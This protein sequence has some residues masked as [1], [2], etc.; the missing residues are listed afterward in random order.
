[1]AVVRFPAGFRESAPGSSGPFAAEHGVA[2]IDVGSALSRPVD[3]IALG[4]AF[5]REAPVLL[6]AARAITSD[7]AEAEDLVQTTFELAIRRVHQLRDPNALRA[8][9][10]TIQTRE[11]FRAIRRLR[12]TIRVSG[13]VPEDSAP[14]L[15]MADQIVIRDALRTL[16]PRM[17]A[18]VVLHHMVGMTVPQVAQAVG[19]SQNT[20][21]TQLKEGLARLRETLDDG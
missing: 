6:A 15:A 7:R 11:A 20:I 8:W 17:R 3:A 5:E 10:L 13:P 4:A 21:K 19:R 14:N 12:R 1:M 16:P 2:E 9:L 18:A